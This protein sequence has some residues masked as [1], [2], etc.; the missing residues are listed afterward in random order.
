MAGSRPLVQ[1]NKK[2]ESSHV[3]FLRQGDYAFKLACVTVG[4]EQALVVTS[5]RYVLFVGGS[6]RLTDATVIR[7]ARSML[8]VEALRIICNERH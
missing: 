6:V 2:T 4:C 7:A 3:V 1:R 8:S 5:Y